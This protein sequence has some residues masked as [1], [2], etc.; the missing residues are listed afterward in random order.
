MSV[1]PVS[2]ARLLAALEAAG[3]E[4]RPAGDGVWFAGC[5][6]CLARGWRSVIEIR[7]T[8]A[9]IVVCCIAAHEPPREIAA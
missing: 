1:L 6:T 3:C 7:G 4:P 5:P 9:G 8:D 2:L